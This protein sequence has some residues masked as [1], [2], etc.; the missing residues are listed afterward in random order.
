MLKVLSDPS[1]WGISA[2]TVSSFACLQSLLELVANE[3]ASDHCQKDEALL[4]FYNSTR[5]H[6][7]IQREKGDELAQKFSSLQL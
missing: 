6:I 5:N 4:A 3:M 1:N 2:F 7:A